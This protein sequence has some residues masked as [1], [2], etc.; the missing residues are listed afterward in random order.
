MKSIFYFLSIIVALWAEKYDRTTI[1]IIHG[2]DMK[3]DLLE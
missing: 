3:I 2:Y 1:N